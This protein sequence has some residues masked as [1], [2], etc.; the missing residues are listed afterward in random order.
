[1]TALFHRCTRATLP[2]VSTA[3]PPAKPRLLPV[4]S[5]AT[6]GA[7]GHSRGARRQTWP[8]PS[9][10]GQAVIPGPGEHHLKSRTYHR[11]AVCCSNCRAQPAACL[12][13]GKRLR[14]VHLKKR[15]TFPP[16]PPEG[17]AKS[18]HVFHLPQKGSERSGFTWQPRTQLR[19]EEHQL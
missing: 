19:A 10:R 13:S 8:V 1:M 18:Q 16:K 3:Q 5:S 9:Q 12:L 2:P 14:D 4:R 17:R 11:T 15:G 6:T 7:R